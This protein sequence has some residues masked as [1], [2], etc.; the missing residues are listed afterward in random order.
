MGVISKSKDQ[1]LDGHTRPPHCSVSSISILLSANVTPFFGR[2][3]GGGGGVESLALSMDSLCGLSLKGV[4]FAGAWRLR[5]RKAILRKELNGPDMYFS[6]RR[7]RLLVGRPASIWWWLLLLFLDF[8][9]N[10]NDDDDD[11]GVK[12]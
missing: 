10:D 1:G 8:I 9:D 3:D 2:D 7:A 6:D 5:L 4:G 12:G 11:D